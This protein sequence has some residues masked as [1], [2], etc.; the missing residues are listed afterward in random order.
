M[1]KRKPGR[2]KSTNPRQNVRIRLPQNTLDKI[3]ALVGSHYA[4]RTAVIESAIMAYL[5][6]QGAV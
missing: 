4:D 2:P 5:K 3:D 6:S 1:T